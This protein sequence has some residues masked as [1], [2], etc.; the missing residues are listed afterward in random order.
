MRLALSAIIVTFAA[1]LIMPTSAAL[2][3][4]KKTTAQA[5]A[6][7]GTWSGISSAGGRIT[8]KIADGKVTYWTNNGFA[9]PKATGSARGNSVNLDDNN[10]WKATMTMQGDGKA[11]ITAAGIGNNGKPAKNTATLTK[12]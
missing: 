9:R 1:T 12:Q 4:P 5:T 7:D 6:W 3:V 11:R 10:G 2:A 8:V